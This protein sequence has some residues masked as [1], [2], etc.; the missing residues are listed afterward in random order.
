MNGE[1]ATQRAPIWGNPEHPLG[2]GPDKPPPT[3]GRT[4]APRLR[5]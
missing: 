4:K 3:S 1:V 2:I 5:S